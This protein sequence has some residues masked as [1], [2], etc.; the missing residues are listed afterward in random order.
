MPTESVIGSLL[1]KGFCFVAGVV[2]ALVAVA[3]RRKDSGRSRVAGAQCSGGWDG[4]EDDATPRAVRGTEK[5][6]AGGTGG[7]GIPVAVSSAGQPTR[8]SIRVST[9]G[10]PLVCAAHMHIPGTE[11]TATIAAKERKR[12]PLVVAAFATIEDAEEFS[13]ACDQINTAIRT[14]ARA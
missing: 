1:A 10:V 3:L 13:A 12:R 9:E 5:S 4:A 7:L 2:V 11:R 8:R 6:P 14:I